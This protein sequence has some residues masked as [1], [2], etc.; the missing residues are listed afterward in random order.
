MLKHFNIKIENPLVFMEQTTMKQFI[1]GDEK[2]KYEVLMQ[3][4][5]FKSLE[6]KWWCGRCITPSFN[7]TEDN[8]SSMNSMLH[9]YKDVELGKKKQIRDEAIEQVRAVQHLEDRQKQILD[10]EKKM[11]WSDVQS[12]EEEIDE[13]EGEVAQIDHTIEKIQNTRDATSKELETILSESSAVDAKIQAVKNDLTIY[14][15]DVERVTKELDEILAPVDEAKM[16]IEMNK[17]RMNAC[18]REMQ[19]IR[20]NINS[21]AEQMRQKENDTRKKQQTESLQAAIDG[22]SS[23][24][25][26]LDRDIARVLEE[27]EGLQ[28][29]VSEVN[30]QRRDALGPP[31]AV[32]EGESREVRREREEHVRRTEELHA[33]APHLLPHRRLRERE[34]GLRAVGEH[35]RVLPVQRAV[36][37]RVLPRVHARHQQ[38]EGADA[39]VPRDLHEYSDR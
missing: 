2:V 13:A 34:E 31:G 1:Q 19:S 14:M 35:D 4:M 12:L 26:A 22:L 23:R 21:I 5:N 27:K 9:R 11:V 10:L 16:K 24:C 30:D 6:Q 36:R 39:Q 28:R 25:E 15:D 8:L 18:D 32:V 3:A 29:S 20:R 38:G 17:S 7:I 37:R 33:A